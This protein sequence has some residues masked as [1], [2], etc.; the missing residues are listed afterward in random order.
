MGAMM[1][2][3]RMFEAMSHY[4]T[5]EC[6]LNRPLLFGRGHDGGALN[7]SATPQPSA[8]RGEGLGIFPASEGIVRDHRDQDP[9]NA[10]GKTQ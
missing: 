3:L 1:L 7:R 10:A 2:K 9:A 5:P 4:Y 8:H 6:A